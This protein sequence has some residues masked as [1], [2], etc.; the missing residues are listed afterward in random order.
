[1]D[2]KIIGSQ[3]ESFSFESNSNEN[4]LEVKILSW[5]HFNILLL[6]NCFYKTYLEF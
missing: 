2:G 4:E 6:T 5:Q 3:N 1:M